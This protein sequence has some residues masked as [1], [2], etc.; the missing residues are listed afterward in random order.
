MNLLELLPSDNQWSRF[1]AMVVV[2]F[3]AL[4]GGFYFGRFWSGQLHH[5]TH[6]NLTVTGSAK[7]YQLDKSVGA[8][9]INEKEGKVLFEVVLEDGKLLPD[10]SH[11][12]GWLVRQENGKSVYLPVGSVDRIRTGKRYSRQTNFGY[13]LEAFDKAVISLEF[14]NK[15]EPGTIV[16]EG[17]IS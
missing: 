1:G 3:V 8:V 12:Q 9:D 6:Y 11:L 17:K 10:N 15:A 13:N 14:T 5:P 4:I 7:Q 2:I 16:M